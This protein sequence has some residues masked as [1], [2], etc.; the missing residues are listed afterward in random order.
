MLNMNI[1]DWDSNRKWIHRNKN[2]SINNPPYRQIYINYVL[3]AEYLI[4]SKFEEATT[5]D[6]GKEQICLGS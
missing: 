1:K 5:F 2:Q 3:I 6:A 4:G